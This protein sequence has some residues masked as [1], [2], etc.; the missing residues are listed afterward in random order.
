MNRLSRIVFFVL[1]AG[2]AAVVVRGALA[3][4][5]APLRVA[6]QVCN[7][8]EE[9]RER[10]E[11]LRAYLE[12]KLGRPVRAFHVN[13]FDFVE[14]SLRKEFDVLQ[15]NGYIYVN[16]KEKAGA[17]LLAREVKRDTGKD[18]GGLIVV[19]T[20]SP[21]RT[22]AGLKGKSMAFGPVL[23]PGGYLAQY[24]TMLRAGL[25]PEKALGRYTFL[26]GAWQHEKVVYAVLYGAV[27][28][29]AVK[30][31]DIERMEAEGKVRASDFR[32][33]AASEPV[34]NCT[35]FAL[36]H[37]DAATAGRVREALLRLSEGDVVAVN[38][39]RLNVLKRD[40]VKG[41]VPADD[42]EFDVLRRMA[43]N[44]NLPPYER[45]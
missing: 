17:T 31:G 45:Y 14:R 12:K 28:A 20:G 22:L 10:F 15:A 40:G 9:N 32:V 5:Q 29:G 26:P 34:P 18:T 11:P 3:P 4:P 13:T 1:V 24:D 38:G 2:T 30:V 8:P 43:R 23:S 16:V 44:A 39:E 35:M 19:R 27:D 6:F 41:Y 7:S 21:V 25:D 36:P 37:V 33:L 42:R